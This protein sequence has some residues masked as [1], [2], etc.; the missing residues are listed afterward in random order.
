MALYRILEVRKLEGKGGF[1]VFLMGAYKG[2]AVKT[3]LVLRTSF[4]GGPSY[5]LLFGGG[6]VVLRKIQIWDISPKICFYDA[7]RQL[8]KIFTFPNLPPKMQCKTLICR[9]RSYFF[10]NLQFR[11]HSL[12]LVTMNVICMKAYFCKMIL[13][14][15]TVNIFLGGEPSVS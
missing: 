5:F 15:L 14:N 13:K 3:R 4:M 9:R 1:I 8:F 2:E 12:S 7:F 10:R 6:G 11:R